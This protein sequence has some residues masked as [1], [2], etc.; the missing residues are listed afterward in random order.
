MRCTPLEYSFHDGRFW[1]FAE[2]GEKFIGPERN[3]NVSLAMFDKNPGFGELRSVQVMGK[4]EIVA[5]MSA[6]YV[7]HAE[8]KKVPVAALRKLFD[9]GRPMHLIRIAPVRMDV[10]FSGFKK[11]GYDARQVMDCTDREPRLWAHCAEGA[12]KENRR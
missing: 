3:E 8:H 4:A 2:G 7:A 9:H 12:Q 6:E 10:L 11:Q 5:P 1:I